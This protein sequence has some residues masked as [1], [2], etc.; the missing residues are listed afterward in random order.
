MRDGHFSLHATLGLDAPKHTQIDSDTELV[1]FFREREWILDLHE[2]RDDPVRYNLLEIPDAVLGFSD[3]WLII[4]LYLGRELY[5]IALI[6][7][8]YTRVDLNWE[9]F[10][11]IRVVGRQLSNFLAQADAQDRLSRA[12]HAV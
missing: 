3:Q 10:D 8:P 7:S 12:M 1:R 9:N 11:L 5:G 6:G 2:Y 4:P